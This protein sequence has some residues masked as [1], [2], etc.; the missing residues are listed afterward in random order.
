MLLHSSTVCALTGVKTTFAALAGDVLDAVAARRGTAL[1]EAQRNELL[2]G[3]ASLPAH[4]DVQG[5]LARLQAAGYRRVAFSNSST[6]L[7]TRQLTNAGLT[8]HFDAIISVEEAGSFKPDPLVYAHAAQRLDR[9]ASDLRL[10]ATHDWDTHGALA[11]GL[12]AAYIDRTGAPYMPVYRRPDVMAPTMDEIVTQI[13]AA[14]AT[15]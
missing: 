1:T 4:G 14:D 6:D 15:P 3:F 9:A 2:G 11:A 13:L 7:V 10:V 5:A 12:R 8:P